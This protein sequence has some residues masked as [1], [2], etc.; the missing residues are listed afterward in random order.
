MISVLAFV[1]PAIVLW[2]T[3][4]ILRRSLREATL[5]PHRF[6]MIFSL[7]WSIAVMLF[8]FLGIS[9]ALESFPDLQLSGLGILLT[10]FNLAISYPVAKF[11]YQR[12]S[13]RAKPPK[14]P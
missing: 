1:V 12:I 9:S 4:Y 8:F 14:N 10:L 5:T 7:G 6:S 13:Q 11:I 3:S 2:I